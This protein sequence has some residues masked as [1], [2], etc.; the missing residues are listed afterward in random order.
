M[1]PNTEERDVLRIVVTRVPVNMME[2][3]PADVSGFQ[4]RILHLSAETRQRRDAPLAAVLGNPKPTL[5]GAAARA[6]IRPVVI[7]ERAR[8]V[9]EERREHPVYGSSDSIVIKPRFYH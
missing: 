7:P 5:H 8:V 9:P 3:P 2:V 6:V 1:T 4:V